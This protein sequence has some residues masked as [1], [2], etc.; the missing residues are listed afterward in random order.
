MRIAPLALALIVVSLAGPAASVEPQALT[1]EGRECVLESLGLRLPPALVQHVVPSEL[2]I[3]TSTGAAAITIGFVDCASVTGATEGAGALAWVSV[4][5]T[6]PS[7]PALQA[8]STAT[9]YRYLTDLLVE[10]DAFRD[11]FAAGGQP[12]DAA[13]IDVD[14]ADVPPS[15]QASGASTA[16]TLDAIAAPDLGGASDVRWRYLTSVP[17]GYALM[18]V[19]F[20]RRHGDIS[21]GPPAIGTWPDGHWLADV[22]GPASG[23]FYAYSHDFA[24][25][26]GVIT[27]VAR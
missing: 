18:D 22:V 7:D 8:P 2:R 26:D 25:R 5:V 24:L 17:D 20:E 15:A 23:G 27:T 4:T 9:K 11:L 14:L 1:F 19:T 3:D 12:F 13:D 10:G 6:R 21:A 16:F